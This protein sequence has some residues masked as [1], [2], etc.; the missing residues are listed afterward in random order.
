[1]I[2]QTLQALMAEQKINQSELARRAGLSQ[3]AVSRA[4]SGKRY[5]LYF[6]TGLALADALGVDPRLL[7]GRQSKSKPAHK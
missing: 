4:L 2:A 7:S 5:R 1:M 3:A 6:D